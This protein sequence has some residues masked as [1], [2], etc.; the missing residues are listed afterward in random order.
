M[1][2]DIG[3][4]ILFLI[5]AVVVITNI[6]RVIRRGLSSL[7]SREGGTQMAAS[8]R[9]AEARAEVE[10]ARR[11]AAVG[12]A[13]TVAPVPIPPSSAPDYSSRIPQRSASPDQPLRQE[14]V[15]VL[16]QALRS[17]ARVD[18]ATMAATS[19]PLPTPPPLQMQFGDQ[20]T[21]A[22]LPSPGLE[23][24]AGGIA[25]DLAALVSRLGTPSG[26]AFAII[27]AAIVGTP[28]ALRTEPQHPGGW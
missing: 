9:Y 2:A 19:A 21:T 20:A 27:A 18:A 1:Q 10:A 28:Q 5:I 13:S 17:G 8:D 12:A 11:Q 3:G 25:P 24:S 22:A 15:D 16:A 6:V 14:L 26:L 4:T 7:T 23:R